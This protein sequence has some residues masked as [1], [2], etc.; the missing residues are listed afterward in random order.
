[1]EFFEDASTT[2]EEILAAAYEALCR[3]GYTDLTIEKIGEEFE[4]STSL[5]YHHYDGKD[6]LLLACLEYLLDRYDEAFVGPDSDGPRERLEESL[7]AFLVSEMPDEQFRFFRALVELRAQAAHDER[8]REHFTR[9]DRLFQAD[10]TELIEAG[11]ETGAFRDVDP[12]AVAAT[13]QT[14]L[15]GALVRTTTSDDD[16]WLESVR[17]EVTACL[18]ARLYRSEGG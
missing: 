11:V 7:A 13:L 10:F 15:A 8:Y 9:S 17:E 14:V 1:M 3:H 4:K 16:E 2:R 5:V 6:E 12:E 18:E